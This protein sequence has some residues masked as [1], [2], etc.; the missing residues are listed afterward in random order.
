MKT[1]HGGTAAGAF[2]ADGIFSELAL[3][4]APCDA[5]KVSPGN[6]ELLDGLGMFELR[7][8]E[9]IHFHNLIYWER[10]NS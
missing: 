2:G 7:G 1:V 8:L 6:P 5:P 4:V 10:S 9:N 3:F